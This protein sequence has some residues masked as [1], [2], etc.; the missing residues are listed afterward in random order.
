MEAFE[1]P[2]KC[3]SCPHQLVME[4]HHAEH[5][6]E[7]NQD[8]VDSAQ[9]HEMLEIMSGVLG[10]FGVAATE[11]EARVQAEA[12]IDEAR[13]NEIEQRMELEGHIAEVQEAALGYAADCPGT[14][15]M[16]ATDKL[17]DT[18]TATVCRSRF[19][20]RGITKDDTVSVERA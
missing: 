7:L 9:A 15:K 6:K 3:M 11:A 18:Y 12:A 16:K 20:P 13:I 19:A 2:T 4:R 8:T 5:V 17:G 10:M 1:K 14:F